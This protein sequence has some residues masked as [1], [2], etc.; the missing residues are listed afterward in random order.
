[1]QSIAYSE[2]LA[3]FQKVDR[4]H[5]KFISGVNTI[6]GLFSEE[7]QDPENLKEN[8]YDPNDFYIVPH[9][10]KKKTSAHS[11]SKQNHILLIGKS[12]AKK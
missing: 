4:K 3:R 9:E 8:I 10:N 5:L 12:E 7:S 2:L 6:D 1:M 11:D